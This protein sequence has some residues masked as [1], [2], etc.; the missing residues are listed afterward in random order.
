MTSIE[1]WYRRLGHLNE[2]NLRDMSKNKSV[3]GLTVK[4][5]QKD[6]F[7]PCKIC[8]RGKQSS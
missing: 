2:N 7:Y 1:K 6:S 5:N 4:L 8:L 3:L